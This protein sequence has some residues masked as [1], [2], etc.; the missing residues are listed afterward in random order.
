MQEHSEKTYCP[1]CTTELSEKTNEFEKVTDKTDLLNSLEAY[2]DFVPNDIFYSVEKRCVN[3]SDICDIQTGGLLNMSTSN[4]N[5]FRKPI[6][7]HSGSL[8]E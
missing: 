6:F 4:F 1:H 5:Y 2:D 8:M 7:S 3:W